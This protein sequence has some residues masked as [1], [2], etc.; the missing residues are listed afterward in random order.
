MEKK[1]NK[2]DYLTWPELGVYE[3]H[4]VI[5]DLSLPQSLLQCS[6]MNE[7]KSEKEGEG[8]SNMKQCKML[9]IFLLYHII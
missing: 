4:F 3:L 6:P 5:I 9:K 8:F 7:A 2:L 1:N